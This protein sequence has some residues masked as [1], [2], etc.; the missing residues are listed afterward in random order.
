MWDGS[1]R[2]QNIAGRSG[3]DLLLRNSLALLDSRITSGAVLIGHSFYLLKRSPPPAG[4]G[5]RPPISVSQSGPRGAVLR[6]A[7][8]RR[9]HPLMGTS[10]FESAPVHRFCVSGLLLLLPPP[11][12]TVCQELFSPRR[13]PTPSDP[14]PSA[15]QC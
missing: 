14:S 7:L 11:I 5:C 15:Q 1:K 13:K 8:F 2:T 10:S 4:W 3:A 12:G 9:S 6:A